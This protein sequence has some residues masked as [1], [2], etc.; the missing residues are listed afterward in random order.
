[1][2]YRF[3][4]EPSND[5]EENEKPAVFYRGQ[6][7]LQFKPDGYTDLVS[8]GGQ[9]TTAKIEIEKVWG[10]D[11]ELSQEK[12]DEGSNNRYILFSMDAKTSTNPNRQRFYFQA[13][14]EQEQG[15]ILLKDGT[16]TMKQDLAKTKGIMNMGFFSAQGILAQFRYVGDFIAKPASGP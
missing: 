11:E 8:H 7:S 10:W 9:D 15:Q 4:D 14:L 6:L 12:E 5:E 16:V 3:A 1:L 2:T 13:R